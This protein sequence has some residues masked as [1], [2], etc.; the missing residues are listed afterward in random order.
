MEIGRSTTKPSIHKNGQ[1]ACSFVEGPRLDPLSQKPL[2]H[3]HFYFFFLL[4]NESFKN[5][6]T[7][8]FL[9][10]LPNNNPL[11]NKCES[12]KALLSYNF[13]HAFPSVFNFF[14][15]MR[16]SETQIHKPECKKI[17]FRREIVLLTTMFEEHIFLFSSLQSS[18]TKFIHFQVI[19]VFASNVEKVDVTLYFK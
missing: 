4:C 3:S 15:D 18:F 10:H 11:P 6:L 2:L 17:F 7:I 13:W 19:C 14:V 5:F 12:C 16:V 8:S 9:G 1:L